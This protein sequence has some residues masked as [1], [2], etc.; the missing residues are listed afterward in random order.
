MVLIVWAA[1]S[2][3]L[4]L[5]HGLIVVPRLPEPPDG[6]ELGKLPYAHLTTPRRLAGLAAMTVLAQAALW[7]VPPEQR[8]L[9]LVYS[10]AVATLVWVDGCT[11]WLPARLSWLVTGELAV[12]AGVAVLLAVDRPQL[13]AR[14]LVGAAAACLLWWGFYR[15]SRGGFGFGD[16]RLAPLTGA[17]GATLGM[18]GWF[19]ALLAG[20]AMAAVWG[21]ISA[22]RHPAPGTVKGFAYG[23]WL[24][25][26]PYV[27]LGWAALA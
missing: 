26:G 3:L 8:P 15:L 11:T 20:S 2:I 22:R 7:F 24:W 25:A 13:L 10:S 12:A 27:A 21:L 5:L 14:L 19:A 4:T 6:A 18:T 1:G 17:M 16:V 9:W 23:P